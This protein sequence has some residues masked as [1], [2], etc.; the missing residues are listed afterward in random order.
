MEIIQ[1]LGYSPGDRISNLENWRSKSAH[2]G[3]DCICGKYQPTQY[4]VVLGVFSSVCTAHS[5]HS[6]TE[7]RLYW[8]NVATICHVS[9]CFSLI[10]C[11]HG[12]HVLIGDHN[13][14]PNP[15]CSAFHDNTYYSGLRLPLFT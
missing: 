13:L 5:N 14:M 9:V 11:V 15:Q 8:I 6:I 2:G 10:L 3:R 12:N 1:L 7:H 4:V